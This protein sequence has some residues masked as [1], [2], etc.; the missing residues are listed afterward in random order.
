MKR[1]DVNAWYLILFEMNKESNNHY[2]G[3]SWTITEE[4][5]NLFKDHETESELKAEHNCVLHSAERID[6]Y[7]IQ[8]FYYRE[9]VFDESITCEDIIRRKIIEERIKVAEVVPKAWLERQDHLFFKTK[10]GDELLSFTGGVM[11]GIDG[12]L[13]FDLMQKKTQNNE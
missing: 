7:L 4:L 8:N 9:P 5:C 10:I 11:S 3:F 1:K 6:N 2:L 13:R 12:K